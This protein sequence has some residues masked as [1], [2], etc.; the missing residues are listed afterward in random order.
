M[1]SRNFLTIDDFDTD[2]KTILVRV[3]LNSPMD[4]QGN[5]L[6]DMRIRSH[7]AT[8][9]DLE[10]A[11]VVL[12]AHQSRPGKKDFTV[13]K[14]HAH[15]MSKHLGRQV[16]YVDDIFGT[17]AKTQIASMEDGDVIMLE[18]VRF[19]SE[20]SLERT[21]AEHASTYLVKKLTP[22]VDI[23]LNDAFAVSHRSHLSVVGFTEVLPSGAGRVM[24]KELVSLERGVKGGERPSIFVLGGAKVDDSLRVA[25]N[26]L[27]NGGADRVLL[28]GVV[29]NVAL[30][31]SGVNIGKAN[32]DFIKSQ[33]Y[34]NQIEKAKSI[35]AK[36]KDKVGLPIDV[37]LND[38]KKR[39]E[40]PVSE[41]DSDSLPINDIGLETIVEFASEIENAK[42]VV[43]NG[44]AGVSEIADFALGTHEIIKAAVKSDFSIIGGGHIS[45]E[46]AHL[47]LGHRFSHISTGGGACIDY[48]AGV[49]LPG[50][51]AMK[52][53]AKKYQEAKNL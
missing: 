6:D 14:P 24:E 13:M 42:T 38:N 39:I 44:P 40:E 22:F 16:S 35:L 37:A 23:F 3:D 52:G 25:E 31:A 4:P 45:A 29:A 2:G 41:L 12:L 19:Y 34:E 18:N 47:G 21:P 11:K 17:Y 1:T 28:T 50:V 26:V 48:L 15:L 43:L 9:K 36:F 27:A 30:A 7:I 20:E 32:M 33:G 46:V 51:E 53:A 10:D 5:I 8:L 49:K